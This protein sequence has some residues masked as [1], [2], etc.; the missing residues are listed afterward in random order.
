MRQS[1]AHQH[2][3]A[4]TIVNHA[5][6]EELAMIFFRYSEEP[7]SRAA[8]RAIVAYRA[9]KAIKTTF[10][11]IQAIQPVVGEGRPQG[12]HPATR[13]FQALRIAVNKELENIESFLTA[14]SSMLAPGGRLVCISFH[15]LE[16]RIV[17]QF[18]KDRSDQFTVLTKHVITASDEELARNNAARSARLRAAEYTTGVI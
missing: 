3:T 18:L 14:T 13:I 9:K 2:T 12:I 17:K 15:S 11:L 5:S 1:P 8:A 6:A 16:D 7:R 10:D 4:A